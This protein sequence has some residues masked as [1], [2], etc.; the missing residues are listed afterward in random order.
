MLTFKTNYHVF[1]KRK[2]VLG[3]SSHEAVDGR[4]EIPGAQQ[5]EGKAY[6]DEEASQEHE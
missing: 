5:E 2:V 3:W 4:Q 6:Q 1:I